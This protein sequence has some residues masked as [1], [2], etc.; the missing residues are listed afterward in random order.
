MDIHAVEYRQAIIHIAMDYFDVPKSPHITLNC[1]DALHYLQHNNQNFDLIFSDLY[2]SEGAHE[3]QHSEDYYLACKEQLNAG[4]ILL[5][6]QWGTDYQSV[7]QS[8]DALRKVF[9]NQVLSLHI[10][11]GNIILF[12][13]P[14]H[15]YQLNRK[16]LFADAQQL[17]MK[18][19]I[20]LLRL[21]RNLWQQN[22]G[23]IKK[24]YS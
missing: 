6:N 3:I 15:V 2:L 17:S 14:E 4:G 22:A 5:L 13:F 16:K 1:D 11:G 20:P 10:K 7:K 12:A 21:A 24:K 19:N 23:M 18:L 9:N 8:N